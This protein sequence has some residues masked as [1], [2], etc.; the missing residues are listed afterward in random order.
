MKVQ[1]Y[2][3]G[4]LSQ[5]DLFGDGTTNYYTWFTGFLT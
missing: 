2:Q 4:G 5:T 1:V 3:G